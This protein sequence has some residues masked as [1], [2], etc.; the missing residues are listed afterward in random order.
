M[1]EHARCD[2]ALRYTQFTEHKML[3]QLIP[4]IINVV[5]DNTNNYD[6]DNDYVR[7]YFVEHVMV[8]K[9]VT[10]CMFKRLTVDRDSRPK[11]DRRN[12]I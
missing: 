10:M 4:I 12:S 7:F 8:W 3:T 11:F 5:V 6:D 9:E 1:L 2:N